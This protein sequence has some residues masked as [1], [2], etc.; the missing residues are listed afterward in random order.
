MNTGQA[1]ATELVAVI[2]IDR[3]AGEFAA[4]EEITTAMIFR[5]QRV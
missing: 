4:G 2:R 5:D 1:E 3:F